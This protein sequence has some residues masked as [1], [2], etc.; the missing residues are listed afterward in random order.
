MFLGL[1]LL[2]AVSWRL[3]VKTQQATLKEYR[4]TSLRVKI[5]K[6][7]HKNF[8]AFDATA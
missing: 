1:S 2:S 5:P 4:Q 6:Y 8:D 7:L 3:T